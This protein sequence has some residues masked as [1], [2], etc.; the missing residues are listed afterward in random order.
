MSTSRYFEKFFENSEMLRL[1][2]HIVH[3]EHA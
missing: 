2:V 3:Y 1:D